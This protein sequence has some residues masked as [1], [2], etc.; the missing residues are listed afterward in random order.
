[1]T[2]DAGR[3]LRLQLLGPVR[4]WRD[5]GEIDLGP[6]HRCAVLAVLALAPGHTVARQDLIG[7][8][9][10][11]ESPTSADGSIYT[12]VSRLRQALEPERAPRSSRGLLASSVA[13]YSLEIDKEQ[14]DAHRFRELRASAAL[15]RERGQAAAAL[16]DIERALGLWR[17][18]ALADLPGPFAA[19]QRSSLGELRLAA[20][21]SRAE[22]L[23]EL[24]RHRELVAE[25]TALCRE[26]PLRERLRALLM[27][28]LHESGR[29]AEALE[30]FAEARATLV[31]TSGLEPGAELRTLHQRLLIGDGA[32]SRTSRPVSMASALA[33]AVLPE[34][35]DCFVGREKELRL[36]RSAV[37]DVVAGRGGV[38]WLEGAPGVG[39]TALLAEVLTGIA[40]RGVRLRWATAQEIDNG[41]PG[42]VVRDCLGPAVGDGDD[43]AEM[44]AA[45]ER[46]ATAGPV[47]LVADDFQWA[48]GASA[49]IWCRLSGLT[50]RLPLLLISSGRTLPRSVPLEQARRKL[51]G[52]GRHLTLGPL[53]LADVF[54]I[55]KQLVGMDVPDRLRQQITFAGGNPY[56][57]REIIAAVVADTPKPGDCVAVAPP[58]CL[59]ERV[60]NHL[61]FLSRSTR[62][63]LQ[64]ASLLGDEFTITGITVASEQQPADLVA[65]VE[66]ALA[67]EILIADS[68]LLRFRHRLVQV[69]LYENVPGA[70]REALHRQLA[71]KLME[72]GASASQ[73]AEQVAAAKLTDPWVGAWLARDFGAVAIEKPQLAVDL[74]NQVLHSASPDLLAGLVRL[75][76]WL[77]REPDAEIRSLLTRTGDPDVVAE[78]RWILAYLHHRRGRSEAARDEVDRAV[79]NPRLAG[80]WRA[81]HDLLLGAL[82]GSTV[83]D[84]RDW[85]SPPPLFSG[86]WYEVLDGD[87][88]ASIVGTDGP[89]VAESWRLALK[90]A[91]PGEIHL[92]NAIHGYWTADWRMAQTELES[93]FGPEQYTS[94]VLYRSGVLLHGLAALVAVYRDQR[95]TAEHHLREASTYTD[96]AAESHPGS[97]FV[98][99]AESGLAELA[100]RPREALDTLQPLTDRADALQSR[101]LW[102]PGLARLAA[103]FEDRHCAQQVLRVAESRY[104][105]AAEQ[106]ILRSYCRALVEDDPDEVV[107]VANGTSGVN[108]LGLAALGDA[109]WLLAKH[110][111]KAEA[112]E[113]FDT[114]TTVYREVGALSAIRRLRAEMKALGCTFASAPGRSRASGSG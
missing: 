70:M 31:G 48:D 37:S 74:F 59:V 39:K 63:M 75:L 76:F 43:G 57:V 53:E 6:G 77:G 61:A 50:G 114:A 62:S 17:G 1:M 78:M 83:L 29:T 32:E 111:R 66:E 95:E 55:A 89:A 22:I 33:A 58:G 47:I 3:G 92:T 19:T 112:R 10:G 25:L 108:Q 94:Y 68:D 7:A 52:I 20:V 84:L 38:V 4:A 49:D 85:A 110:R 27:Q 69:S 82:S 41:R 100:G 35:P 44:V 105:R 65:C 64:S 101:F 42:Q 73:V 26:H 54:D 5:D 80:V 87:A 72:V 93:L 13:G 56:Y 97:D 86:G 34:R 36:V 88:R 21:E 98:L 9:W 109:A 18:D 60:N 8:L 28:A 12:Y 113:A 107:R 45:V 16:E 79:G 46:W 103:R 91:L 15:R 2:G 96:P 102:L 104:G 14:V 67:A 71:E 99:M 11:E 40:A 30:V 106:D 24:G 90:E 51:S 23:M 81:R